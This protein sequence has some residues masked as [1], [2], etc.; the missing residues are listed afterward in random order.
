MKAS[1]SSSASTS[2]ATSTSAPDSPRSGGGGGGDDPH[3]K[4]AAPPAEGDFLA[5]QAEDAQV[6]M[7]AAWTD[8][9]HALA[10][11]ADIR[12]WTKR[13]PWF[14]AGGALAAGV[15]AGYLLTP[16]DKD[17]AKELWEK[18]KAKLAGADRK[19]VV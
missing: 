15:A 11:G 7:A 2:A 8:L 17:E 16:R 3:A 14:A 12:A 10:S 5:Q 9:K 13:Y 1:E 19:S 6:A 4:K 18:L